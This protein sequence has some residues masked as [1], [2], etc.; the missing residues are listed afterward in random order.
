MNAFRSILVSRTSLHVLLSTLLCAVATGTA[1]SS[2][3]VDASTRENTTR[4]GVSAEDAITR[5][6]NNTSATTEGYRI[7][8][9]RQVAD[10]TASGLHLRSLRGGI[11]WHW[12]LRHAG[13]DGGSLA[14]VSTADVRPESHASGVVSYARGGIV[15]QYHARV[16]GIEQRFVIA[17]PLALHGAD[18]LVTGSVVTAG[19]LAITAE[20]WQWRSTDGAVRL[21]TVRVYDGAGEQIPAS[22]E[23]TADSTRIVVDGAALARA[24]YPVTIDPEIGAN[25]FRISDM[26]T[27]G[28]SAVDGLDPA[29]AYNSTSNEYLVVWEGDDNT[30]PVVDSEFEIYGQRID[31]ATGAEVG[32]NDFRISDMGP[33][34]TVAFSALDPAVA[35]SSTSNEYLVVWEGD[36][37]T[38]P[39]VDGEFEIFGQR[40]DASGAEVGTN[41]FRIS[42]MG[43]DGSTAFNALDPAVAYSS[44]NEEYLVVW[45]GDDNTSPLVDGEFEIFGQRI[46][47]ATGVEVGTNDF[48]ISDMGPVGSG[49]YDA[50]D[51]AV[52]YNSTGDEYLVVWEGDDNTAPLINEEFEIFGQR[53][54]A[55]TGAEAGTNDFR[56]SD[57]GP[58][59][60][61]AFAGFAPS[62]AY[63]DVD[64]EYLVVWEGDDSTSPLVDNEFEIFGQRLD[65]SGAE[66][67]TND[68]RISDMGPDGDVTHAALSPAVGYNGT[69][70]EYLVVWDGD[71][72]TAP[73][74]NEEFEIFGQRIDGATGSE[75]GDNDFR[76]SNMGPNGDTGFDGEAAVAAHTSTNNEYLVVWDGDQE[77]GPLVNG[78]LE[79]YG[80]RFVGTTCGNG[81]LETGEL[82]DEGLA[83]GTADS[84]CSA[85]CT[86]QPDQTACTDDGNV[87]TDDR[88][89]GVSPVCQHPDNAAACDDGV[90]CNGADTCSGGACTVNAGD[91]CPGPDGDGNCAQSC[92]EIADN[93]AA[94]DPDGSVCDDGLFC[95]GADTCSG[96][97][98][99]VNTGDP[100]SGPDGDTDCAESCDEGN[101]DC[102]GSDP[103]GTL[104]RAD[105]GECDV[106]ETCSGGSCPA[107]GFETL[108]AP[109]T[110][111][112]ET[113]TLDQCDGNGVCEHPAGNAGAECRSDGG[114]C[115][116]AEV[117]DGLSTSC[118][119]DGLETLG[120]PCT[121][122]GETCTLD[123]CDGNG[124]C[125]HP[126]GNAGAECRSDGG[127]CDVAEQCDG[128]STSCPADGL[129]T[130]GA[131]CTDDGET[132]TLDQCDGNGVCEHPAGNAGAECR[133]DGG[134]C[135]VAE[136]CDG[137]STSCPADGLATLGA[138]CTDDGETCTLDQCDGNGACEHPAG[139]AGAE[140]RSDGGECDVAEQ[141][142]G[143]STSCPADAFELA[144]TACGDPAD[145][146][147]TH[148]DSCNGGG[149]CD[150]NDEPSGTLCTDDGN[151]CTEDQCDGDGACGHPAGNVGTECRADGG[152]CDV[153][154]QCDGFSTACPPNGY[155]PSGTACGDPADD[156]CTNADTCDGS[157]NC[158]IND[159]PAGIPCED[160]DACTSGDQCDGNG[161]CNIG[162]P[163]ICPACEFC[164][165]IGGC[166]P[167]IELACEP[168][169]VG[170][171]QLFV[172]NN[173][174]D[175]LD[176]IRYKQKNIPVD[177]TKTDFGD[178]P[179]G[180]TY[181]LCIYDDKESPGSPDT[182]AY[183]VNIP[184]GSTWTEK[185]TGFSNSSSASNPSL[186]VR[187][188]RGWAG[189][190]AV[191]VDARGSALGLVP[192]NAALFFS[193]TDD[194]TVVL[195]A[196]DAPMCFRTDF[197][198]PWSQNL[199][200]K[201]KDKN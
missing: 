15:E 55:A 159:E 163:T 137:L 201:Y 91:P 32:T 119:A 104:C 108:G 112:G 66:V 35:Y 109:C 98:C 200:T 49:S 106:A 20:G 176:R 28:N 182:L 95:N 190:G 111:D 73:L 134:E 188:R 40:L 68:F 79:I 62:V 180:T 195:V 34:G 87:C 140:C 198:A 11:E 78:E 155:A 9:P 65:A 174:D 160:G 4:P 99:T 139:N 59:A 128:L 145:D 107:D 6:V 58:D 63:N 77:A 156:D 38:S 154:E 130:L 122:D 148:P 177:V 151:V 3:H 123:Q 67:G 113:C 138:P 80:Q 17:Q 164:D 189:G 162:P 10:F 18:L 179:A 125:E 141:C 158:Q 133:S 102:L 124:V 114:E 196:D 172:L 97:A 121:D 127:E 143:L 51:P 37:D 61:A 191:S 72:D 197:P 132:C 146:E 12:Q 39:L 101:D 31:A 135:D 89:N 149:S 199:P 118:P 70:N 86:L 16:H 169:A 92:D 14:S 29:V 171:S 25:D 144:G 1:W 93:C 76:L 166:I 47:V 167:A 56:I 90:F 19:E 157:N 45:E 165:S 100:C 175:A 110:D 54:D 5:A 96:G 74:I 129:E 115:D 161:A 120:A 131:P 84:C 43:T 36:D 69:S 183:S 88:C 22:M 57:M 153:A 150:S 7:T 94:A 33:D 147:C 46:D 52:A 42:D 192:H 48:R 178:P 136:Q 181:Q 83:T 187:L 8:H 75:I 173:D 13:P 185:P 186:K 71:D 117:C 44:A 64:D 2:P 152:E 26:G 21:G 168:A 85:S 30:S 194:V 41:D 50:L 170:K 53:I 193:Q 126:A 184:S 116:V 27:D 82:C 23:V 103:D 81:I 24:S 105:A 60:S 142:D